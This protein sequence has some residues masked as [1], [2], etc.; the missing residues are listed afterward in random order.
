M[1]WIKVIALL[2]LFLVSCG[3]NAEMGQ[4]T[5][6]FPTT[7]RII[8]GLAPTFTPIPSGG[9]VAETAVFTSDGIADPIIASD[10]TR[11]PTVSNEIIV[12][13]R[14]ALPALNLNR[15]L[16]GTA[17]GQISIYDEAT[18]RTAKGSQREDILAELIPALS[19]TTLEP[20]DDECP[21]CLF[22]S[23]ELPLTGETR[24]GWLR[25]PRLAASLENYLAIALGPHFPPETIIGLRRS[26]SSYAPAH[27]LALTANG[28]LFQW[29]ATE[30]QFV[31]DEDNSFAPAELQSTLNRL[32]L[33]RLQDSY[34]VDCA[35]S[36]NELLYLRVGE[37]SRAVQIVCPEF[38]LSD[39][40]L[41]LYLQLDSLMAA[42]LG[43][44]STPPP[45]AFPLSSL[46]DYQRAEDG[47]R[48]TLFI[49]GSAIIATTTLSNTVAIT[50][51]I[52]ATQ[53]RNLQ[54]DLL[55]TGVLTTGLKTFHID[56]D[57]EVTNPSRLLVRGEEGVYDTIWELLP[58]PIVFTTLNDILDSFLPQEEH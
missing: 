21:T 30:D 35:L 20:L 43:N 27:S 31:E 47:A 16:S 58:E 55:A 57:A 38:A 23:Y 15:T 49:D 10:S 12:N 17:D 36:P 18:G 40:L 4:P 26:A 48:M 41:P 14:Y 9:V 7:T 52:S 13:L 2:L 28:R 56:P 34:V 53:L 51:T 54:L 25:D 33:A 3:T 1:R 5:V 29:S 6:P 37:T 44:E 22:L 32:P 11:I 19:V 39:M 50:S 46:I 42:K 8:G 45:A 24:E